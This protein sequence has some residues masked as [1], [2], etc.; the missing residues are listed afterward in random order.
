LATGPD[1]LEDYEVLVIETPENLELR[2]PLAGFGP[3]FL[4]QLLDQLAIGLI[5]TVI[6]AIG[7]SIVFGYSMGSDPEST[8]L[9]VVLL[10]V[11]ALFIATLGYYLF[12]EYFWNG[13]TPGKRLLGIR[14]ICRGG[15]PLTFR[16]V[17]IRN[18]LR[19][20][21]LLPTYGFV[22]LICFFSTR[23]QQRLGDL[24]ADT[25]V[26][27]EFSSRIPYSWEATTGAADFTGRAM[28]TP[29]ASY[30][31]QSY[32][33]RRGEIDMAQRI[34]LSEG[35][36]NSLGHDAAALSLSERENYLASIMQMHMAALR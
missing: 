13:Q 27:R 34:E 10:M 14:V 8:G 11:L 3:R 20:V 12:F 22:G 23:N 29:R 26:V 1:F 7:M 25:V 33:S 19:L 9:Q 6:I 4:A 16:E 17:L 2:L 30:V 32:L 28:L 36:I 24:A 15:M 35:I 5:V 31:I 18:L 21:D